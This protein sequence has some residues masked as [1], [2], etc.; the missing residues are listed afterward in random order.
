MYACPDSTVK[1]KR[2]FREARDIMSGKIKAKSCSSS[3]E[4]FNDLDAE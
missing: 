1:P 4:L 2:P 3:R